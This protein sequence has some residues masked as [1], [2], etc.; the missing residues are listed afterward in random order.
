MMETEGVGALAE[1]LER[2]GAS[3]EFA[4]VG[5]AAI[6]AEPSS[7]GRFPRVNPALCKITGYSA[8][9]LLA[10]TLQAI[11]QPDDLAAGL[12]YLNEAV[13]GER[14]AFLVK[15]RYVDANGRVVWMLLNTWALPDARG[16]PLCLFSEVHEVTAQM[17]AEARCTTKACTTP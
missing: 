17:E 5:M 10:T 3:F 12:R 7:L 8:E 14:R 11:T 4:P 15:N 6:S 16:L 2:F 1:A 9:H 13:R